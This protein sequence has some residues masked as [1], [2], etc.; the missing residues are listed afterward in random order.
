MHLML[1]C[2]V[3]ATNE[4]K[5]KRHDRVRQYVHWKMCKHVGKYVNKHWYE[6]HPAQGT[7]IEDIFTD[8]MVKENGPVIVVKTEEKNKKKTNLPTNLI[9]LEPRT[10]T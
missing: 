2:S 1:G 5:K 7:E 9:W 3:L 4:Y 10:V 8:R 6:H